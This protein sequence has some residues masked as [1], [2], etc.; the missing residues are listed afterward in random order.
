MAVH[1]AVVARRREMLETSVRAVSVSGDIG[2]S[3]RAIATAL[4]AL[5]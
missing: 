4:E 1:D 2:P 5:V 3:L